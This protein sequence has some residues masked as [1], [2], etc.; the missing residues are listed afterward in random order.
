[1]PIGCRVVFSL[2]L[3]L[4]CLHPAADVSVRTARASRG[5]PSYSLSLWSTPPDFYQVIIDNDIFRPLGWTKPKPQ[6]G[7]KLVAT[8]MKSNG[9]HKALIRD[10]KTRT[11]HYAGVGDALATDVIL[12][13]ISHLSVTLEE[14]GTATLY[15]LIEP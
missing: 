7:F 1:M 6:I 12:S 15:R 3:I 8:L 10:I 14:H 5:V 4:L 2:L 9:T 11:L 13:D